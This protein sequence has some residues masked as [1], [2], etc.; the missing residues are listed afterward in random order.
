[1][2]ELSDT[3]SGTESSDPFGI[4]TERSVSSLADLDM[5]EAQ[6]RALEIVSELRGSSGSKQLAVL[7]E[8][9]SIGSRT[10]RNAGRQLG[11]VAGRLAE[12]ADGGGS[13][14]AISDDLVELRTVLDRVDPGSRGVVARA[15]A[16]V[17][18]LRTRF[19]SRRLTKVAVLHE[20]VAKQVVI[21]EDRLTSGRDLLT[22]DNVELR[23]LYEDVEAQQVLVR[24]QVCLGELLLTH[25]DEM[26]ATTDDPVERDRIGSAQH[27]VAVRVQDLRTMDEVHR[28]YF[29]SIELI[30][31]TNK[32]LG[33]GVDR[34]LAL[35]TNV[36][37]VGLAIQAALVRQRRVLE[38]NER[39]REFLGDLLVNNAAA[40]REQTAEIGDLAARPVVALDKLTHAHDD[41]L[42]AL[43]A[44][45][46]ARSEG[47]AAARSNIV[48][49]V[50]MSG[51]LEHH[52]QGSE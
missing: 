9:T 28:Q 3:E 22:R 26:V 14:K 4:T 24:R 1:M 47:L 18:G 29:V 45:Q 35:A 39:T 30:R 46:H 32:Q 5:A 10:Q 17:P 34:T 43:D 27:D 38:A 19:I 31:Q 52:V 51:E 42:A 48:Q 11:L 36:V 23:Q 8:V 15:V 16:H 41:L 20:S 6:H 44:A 12:F 2:T 25:L 49:L 21:I 13:A 50:R 7:D 37:T 33:H 40:I